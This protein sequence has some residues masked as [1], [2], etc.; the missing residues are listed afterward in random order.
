MSL[1]AHPMTPRRSFARLASVGAL[2]S[3]RKRIDGSD[4]EELSACFVGR[5]IWPEPVNLQVTV[6]FEE[7]GG[8]TKLTMRS[9][10][11]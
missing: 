10:C 4:R 3:P 11:S 8:K 2:T 1:N 7:Q 5:K 9:L 6:T